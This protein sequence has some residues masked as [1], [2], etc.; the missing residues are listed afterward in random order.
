MR[1]SPSCVTIWRSC[2]HGL[3]KRVYGGDVFPTG[4]FPWRVLKQIFLL[5]CLRRSYSPECVE[6]EFCELRLLGLLRSSSNPHSR[7]FRTA[8]VQHLW[9]SQAEIARFRVLSD[10]LWLPPKVPIGGGLPHGGTWPNRRAAMRYS[11]ACSYG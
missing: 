9:I 3:C 5:G 4:S 2:A 8:P 6:G 7:K 10:L 1:V 11:S